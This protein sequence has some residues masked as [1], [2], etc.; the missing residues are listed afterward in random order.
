MNRKLFTVIPIVA[1]AMMLAGL[2]MMMISSNGFSAEYF[3]TRAGMSYAF[4]AV[5]ALVAFALFMLVSHPAIKKMLA[6][7][8]RMAQATDADKA[9]IGAEIA[10]VRA[11]GA[12][13][14]IAN[15]AL[16]TGAVVAMAIGRFL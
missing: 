15:A 12:R 2:R 8:P 7:G 14:S 10:A 3:H 5:C 16:L 6:L 13:A 1:A 9:A 4:G 11:R